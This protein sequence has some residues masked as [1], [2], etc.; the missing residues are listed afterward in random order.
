[1][2][3]DG[4]GGD[5]PRLSRTSSMSSEAASSH[6]TPTGADVGGG[7]DMDFGVMDGFDPA[8]IGPDVFGGVM[9]PEARQ[10]LI[11]AQTADKNKGKFDWARGPRTGASRDLF[12]KEGAKSLGAR[13]KEF[14]GRQI[15]KARVDG[16]PAAA[17]GRFKDWSANSTLFSAGTG[18]HKTW[19]SAS[20]ETELP[21]GVKAQGEVH[22]GKLWGYG[23]ASAE[24]DLKNAEVKVGVAGKVEAR[25]IGAEGS[26]TT[27]TLGNDKVAS[28]SG[29]A[30]GKAYVGADVAGDAGLRINPKEGTA[31]VGAGVEA[32]AGAKAMAFARPSIKIAGEDISTFS[33]VSAEA[34]AGIGFKAKAE[35]GIEKGRLKAKFELGAALGVGVGVGVNIDINLVGVAKVGKKAAVAVADKAKAVYASGSEAVTSA[36]D[37]AQ[38]KVAGA[39]DSVKSWWGS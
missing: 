35:A 14:T 6:T 20:G 16:E 2:G 10:G 17:D 9:S 15:G 28:I 3:I 8:G 23:M 21:G 24:V 12:K 37:N 25:A 34:Y 1:M 13:E 19:K 33:S 27:K 29:S 5:G 31:M 7:V 4:I 36:V 39:F 38:S 32:F 11:E 22:A 26:L 30:Y 18:G